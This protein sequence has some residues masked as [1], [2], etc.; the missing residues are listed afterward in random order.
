M[1]QLTLLATLPSS[2]LLETHFQVM[3][4]VGTEEPLQVM[5]REVT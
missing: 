3:L 2:P 5:A 1:M 4:P